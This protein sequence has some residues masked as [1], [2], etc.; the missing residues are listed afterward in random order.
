MAEAQYQAHLDKLKQ[1]D[2]NHKMYWTYPSLTIPRE[3]WMPPLVQLRFPVLKRGQEEE[4][5]KFMF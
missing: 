4:V 2:K 1:K 5:M 3:T